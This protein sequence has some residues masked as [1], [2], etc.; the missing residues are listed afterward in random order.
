MILRTASHSP[1]RSS[2]NDRARGCIFSE[3]LA[4]DSAGGFYNQGS[5][6]L[7][8]C[9][10]VDNRT[11]NWVGGGVCIG[12]CPADFN[13]DGDVDAKDLAQLLGNWGPCP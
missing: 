5:L 11:T 2:R 10:F 6:T 12:E 7:T 4:S 9:L 3:N 13:D 8:S 1:R